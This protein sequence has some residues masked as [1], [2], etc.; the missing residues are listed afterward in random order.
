VDVDVTMVAD[1]RRPREEV[2]AFA[3]DPRNVTRWYRNIH[4]VEVLTDGPVT[5]GS[6][7][8]FVARFLGRSIDYTYEVVELVAGERMTMTTASG[9][10][11]MTTE[12]AFETLDTGA[13]RMTMRNH[14]TPS[15]FGAVAAP[16]LRRAMQHAMTRDLRA[17]TQL[18][19][20]R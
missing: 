10:F 15:G 13:T 18:L 14:G 16:V 1:I 17:L 20:H 3:C 2:A 7:V 6:R 19:E 9:P 5:V 11:P 4:T 8:R 12:Y